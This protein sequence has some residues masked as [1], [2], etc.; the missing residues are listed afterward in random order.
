[1]CRQ[2]VRYVVESTPYST[3]ILCELQW[4]LDLRDGSF[5]NHVPGTAKVEFIWSGSPTLSWIEEIVITT[6]TVHIDDRIYTFGSQ[7]P[8]LPLL[9]STI[10][11]L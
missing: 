7:Q 6:I 4:Q 9:H 10:H 3:W 11:I 8:L 2:E 1:M 5:F